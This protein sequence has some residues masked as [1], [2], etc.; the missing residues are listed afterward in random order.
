LKTK[1]P[2]R[3]DD[4]RVVIAVLALM[5]IACSISRLDDS[6]QADDFDG[7]ILSP[8][9]GGFGARPPL[10]DGVVRMDGTGEW[11]TGIERTGFSENEGIMIDLR[12]SADTDFGLFFQAG[13]F[14]S[15]DWRQA[16][17]EGILDNERTYTNWGQFGEHWTVSEDAF[18]LDNGVWYTVVHRVLPGGRFSTQ[19]WQRDDPSGYI[20]NGMTIPPDEV[21]WDHRTW[22]F[23]ISIKQGTLRLDN[24]RALRFP[25]NFE[26]PES[27]PG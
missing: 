23:T 3:Y 2:I 5:M 14:E 16:G 11:N 24:F 1:Q 21:E 6:P 4:Y 15:E 17:V 26:M 8:R 7:D 19:I 18:V 13:L 25:S 12:Y 9:W 27:P 22:L 10:E 20:Y